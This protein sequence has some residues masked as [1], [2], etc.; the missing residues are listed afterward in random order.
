MNHVN[1][2]KDCEDLWKGDAVSSTETLED[3]FTQSH[4]GKK[5][6]HYLEKSNRGRENGRERERQRELSEG[7]EPYRAYTRRFTPV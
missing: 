5:K 7:E 6:M 3:A 2:E 1:H 4:D